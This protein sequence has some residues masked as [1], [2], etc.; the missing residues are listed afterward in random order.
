MSPLPI[1]LLT[2]PSTSGQLYAGLTNGDVWRSD[3][4]GDNWEKLPFN[5]SAIR[6]SL[7]VLESG[8]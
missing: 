7:I 5:F 3:D 1:A 6:R 4:Y 8:K 2:H